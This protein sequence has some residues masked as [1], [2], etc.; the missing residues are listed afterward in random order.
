[1]TNGTET[2]LAGEK[3]PWIEPAIEELHVSETAAMPGAGKDGEVQHADCTK[4]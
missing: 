2:K 4:S 1:M 3:E